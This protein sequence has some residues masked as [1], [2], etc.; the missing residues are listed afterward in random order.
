MQAPLLQQLHQAAT[1]GGAPGQLH[2]PTG[3]MQGLRGG[4]RV[5]RVRG[6]REKVPGEGGHWGRGH[7]DG[8]QADEWGGGRYGGGKIAGREKTRVN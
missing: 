7:A 5:R 6:A 1:P 2:P 8:G 3:G 4:G